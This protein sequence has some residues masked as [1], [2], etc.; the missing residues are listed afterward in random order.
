PRRL[1]RPRQLRAEMIHI[2]AAHRVDQGR[3][4][5]SRMP[6]ERQEISYDLRV[7]LPVEAVALDGPRGTGLVDEGTL[8]RPAPRA[9]GP[10]QRPI[11]V[12]QDELHAANIIDQW[13][14]E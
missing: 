7:G 10:E 6:S 5:R 11:D 13:M 8:D 1:A 12:E 3:I 4:L 2:T 9:V 14:D